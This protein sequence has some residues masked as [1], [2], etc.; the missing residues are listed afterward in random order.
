MKKILLIVSIL[1]ILSSFT[2]NS[3]KKGL[4]YTFKKGN[5]IMK[6][7]FDTNNKYLELNKTTILKISFENISVNSF[8]IHGVGIQ[9]YGGGKNFTKCKIHPIEKYLVNKNLEISLFEDRNGKKE[10]FRK[11]FVPVK[12]E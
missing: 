2:E 3:Q 8:S 10:L 6:L 12:V 9:I 5:R 1:F 11:F 4:N 7:E